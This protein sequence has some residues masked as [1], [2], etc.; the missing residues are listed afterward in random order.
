LCRK[1]IRV[2]IS[3]Q[4]TALENEK[5]AR[6]LSRFKQINQD[7]KWFKIM[8]KMINDK[9][10]KNNIVNDINNLLRTFNAQTYQRLQDY[11][12]F[13]IVLKKIREEKKKAKTAGEVEM[14]QVLLKHLRDKTFPMV[15]TTTIT[16]HINLT[17][18]QFMKTTVLPIIEMNQVLTSNCDKQK[19]LLSP[20]LQEATQV[21]LRNLLY[22][23]QKTIPDGEKLKKSQI[24]RFTSRF[25]RVY[26]A[27][28]IAPHLNQFERSIC[29]QFFGHAMK[30]HINEY[31][32]IYGYGTSE[33]ISEKILNVISNEHSRK[34][35]FDKAIDEMFN[36]ADDNE[37]DVA[38]DQDNTR[39]ERLRTLSTFIR[40][41]IDVKQQLERYLGNNI[42]ENTTNQQNARNS[43]VILPVRLL[44]DY[45][46]LAKIKEL[47]ANVI[48]KVLLSYLNSTRG[49]NKL[50]PVHN[51][52]YSKLSMDYFAYWNISDATRK[53]PSSECVKHDSVVK[54]SIAHSRNYYE[55]VVDEYNNYHHAPKPLILNVTINCVIRQKK[56]AIS[57]DRWETMTIILLD[58]FQK[59]CASEKYV[60]R[61]FYNVAYGKQVLLYLYQSKGEKLVTNL[62]RSN[63]LTLPKKSACIEYLLLHGII[64][65]DRSLI[66]AKHSL[67]HIRQ[68]LL[69]K[70]GEHHR[71]HN[72][73]RSYRAQDRMVI[74]EYHHL[75]EIQKTR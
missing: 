67:L 70:M 9:T 44:A 2:K 34:T 16:S 26:I 21:D 12:L 27:I 48:K 58:Y 68:Q 8:I 18:D 22:Y 15:E 3:L 61:P 75:K 73:V 19:L 11:A 62:G 69:E 20:S 40:N 5:S 38:D 46:T 29:G 57:D 49:E 74:P 39:E 13:R 54:K 64:I 32:K 65:T 6:D 41:N 50:F 4:K 10:L 37:A 28:L 59:T 53:N 63:F 23:W 1:V 60:Y 47:H 25:Y 42:R 17:H 35:T 7:V 36:T 33:H 31:E 51:I 14:N 56:L 71:K 24:K 45:Y 43:V 72:F 52:P 30:M 66:T 55:F